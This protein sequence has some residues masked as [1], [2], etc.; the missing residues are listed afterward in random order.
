MY[1]PL[2]SNMALHK[3]ANTPTESQRTEIFRSNRLVAHAAD[4]LN[5]ITVSVS[6]SILV[7]VLVVVTDLL[8]VH[9]RLFPCV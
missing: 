6:I 9:A 7:L 2:R 5:P 8:D 4:I 3:L 1:V